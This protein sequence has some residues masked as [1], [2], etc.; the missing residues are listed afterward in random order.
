M[1]EQEEK[2]E[3]E[4][5][6][7]SFEQ[8]FEQ[9]EEDVVWRVSEDAPSQNNAHT[10]IEYDADGIPMGNSQEEKHIRR[11]I[12]HEFIQ[13]WRAN[14][15][16]TPFV[17]NENLNENIKINQLFLIES[18]S[19]A[20]GTYKSTKAALRFE[21]VMSK[22]QKIGLTK[23]KEGNSNQKPFQQMLVMRYT[24]EDLGDVKMTVDIRKVTKE[25]VQ[26]SITVPNEGTPFI[27]ETMRI[28]EKSK[29]QK[30]K[31]HPK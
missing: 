15:K 25:K 10:E 9:P 13:Q 16:D 19:H 11:N 22:A 12:I 3:Y 24:S 1:L 6:S 14:H 17:F 31:K 23:V 20:I 18:V 8:S 21:E 2:Y 7:I 4:L 26:Y 30:R 29:G 5:I 28:S 27:D